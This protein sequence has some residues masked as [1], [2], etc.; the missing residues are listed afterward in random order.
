MNTPSNLKY[1]KTDEWFDP[2][3]GALGLTD[4]A[5]SQLSDIV[6]VEV[7]L[8]PGETLEAGKAVASVESVKASAEI[9][10]PVGGKVTEVN[11]ALSEKPETLNSSPYE[12]GWLI[13]VEGAVP[14]SDL[15]DAAAYE[16]YCADRSH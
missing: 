14:G 1:T 7:Q 12:G 8:E 6:F 5:Q 10:S 16:K 13:K 4:Y 9:Y 2:A 3:T 11:K 15:M